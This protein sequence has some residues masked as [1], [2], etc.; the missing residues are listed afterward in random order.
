MM[1]SFN[2]NKFIKIMTK[3]I[4][5]LKFTDSLLKRQVQCLKMMSSR[6]PRVTIQS[7]L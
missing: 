1:F 3:P 2:H 5:P 4:Q 6:T 7:H